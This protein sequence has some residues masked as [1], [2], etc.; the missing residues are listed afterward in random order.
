[1]TEW[2]TYA[3]DLRTKVAGTNTY[4]SKWKREEDEYNNDW[5]QLEPIT[6]AVL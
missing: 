5:H 2:A 3:G 1:M 4:T 6:E